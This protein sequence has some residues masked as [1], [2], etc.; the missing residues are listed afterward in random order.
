VYKDILDFIKNHV[1]VS[2]PSGN[3]ATIQKALAN[4]FI[5]VKQE[6]TSQSDAV[7]SMS[8]KDLVALEAAELKD[9]WVDGI[10]MDYRNEYEM[11]TMSEPGAVMLSL[12][13]M[14]DKVSGNGYMQWPEPMDIT[15]EDK[16]C[17]LY[18][19]QDRKVESDNSIDDI[20]IPELKK[21]P[22]EEPSKEAEL[23]MEDNC[24]IVE[25]KEGDI[26]IMDY[27]YWLVYMMN[28]TLLTMLPAYWADGFDI[29]V[30]NAYIP[31]PAVYIPIAPPVPINILHITLVFGIA[32]RGIF[33]VPIAII[34]NMSSNDI[35]AMTPV[36]VTLEQARLL[37][38]KAVNE[39]E[40]LI[41]NM[42]RRMVN[43]LYENNAS[44]QLLIDKFKT[45]ASLI[46]SIPIE[47]KEGIEKDILK[48]LFGDSVD[49]RQ[50]ITRLEKL[51]VGPDPL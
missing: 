21:D 47:N 4:L 6:T 49:T 24:D 39:A 15:I 3:I 31:L 29:P 10:I 32:I 34:L 22:I 44:C 27:Q 37:F 30:I 18:E 8:G 36:M 42:L 19:F 28:A 41:P 45:Y 13:A 1:K 23:D 20:S 17:K 12:N 51:G 5:F 50:I 35:N 16:L 11:G 25:P 33:V 46:R 14:V 48:A 38:E 43:V 7:S 26:T 9:F 40:N 2:D